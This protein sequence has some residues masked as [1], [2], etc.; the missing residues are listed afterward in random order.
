MIFQTVCDLLGQITG[1]EVARMSMKTVILEDME[2]TA[3]DLH[4][5]LLAL[6][7]E[8]DLTWDDE[9]AEEM[10]TIGHIVHYIEENI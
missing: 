5:L 1:W 10:T 9:T 6:E 4:E 2:A 8:F 7:S 3:D